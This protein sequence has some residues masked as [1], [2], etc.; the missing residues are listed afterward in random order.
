MSKQKSKIT[1]TQENKKEIINVAILAEEP[2]G[3][4]SGKHYF[5]IILNDYSWSKK[6]KTYQLDRKSVV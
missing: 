4:G 3:W 1:K 5:P 2:L 6:Q